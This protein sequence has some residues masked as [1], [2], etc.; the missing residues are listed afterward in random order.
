MRPPPSTEATVAPEAPGPASTAA[1]TVEDWCVGG[2]V[3][4]LVCECLWLPARV[5]RRLAHSLEVTMLADNDHGEN[6]ALVRKSLVR[7]VPYLDGDPILAVTEEL[8]CHA[9]F[10]IH[11]AYLPVA[12]LGQ[13]A[14]GTAMVTYS[15]F[16]RPTEVPVAYLRTSASIEALLTFKW[17]T[18]AEAPHYTRPPLTEAPVAKA[19]ALVAP[20]GPASGLHR[21]AP[22]AGLHRRLHRGGLVCGSAWSASAC[23]SPRG[24]LGAWRT[25]L[26]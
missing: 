16:Y 24:S 8:D 6:A 17:A 22:R 23:G 14:D 4:C 20:P 5:T 13:T 3:E 15:D 1:S 21:R 10:A 7:N 18:V 12:V 11:E 2:I 25:L 9:W 26:R 19:K